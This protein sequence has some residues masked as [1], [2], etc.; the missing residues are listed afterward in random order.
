MIWYIAIVVTILAIG[1]L[2]FMSQ[3]GGGL[4]N[5]QA[6]MATL[7]ANQTAS[8]AASNQ[9]LTDVQKLLA[10]SQTLPNGMVAVAQSDID[11]LTASATAI[12]TALAGETTAEQA[13]EA[14]DAGG[15]PAAS[16]GSGVTTASA[17]RK[18]QGS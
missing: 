9:L 6:Q 1:G 2:Y 14:I 16:A 8:L 12:N 3:T 7:Q 15:T 18:Q 10:G 17:L 13:Q 5:L 11:A 4:A